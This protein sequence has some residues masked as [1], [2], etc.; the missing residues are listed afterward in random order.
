M[1]RTPRKRAKANP[2]EAKN[3]P[4]GSAELQTRR[5][6][7]DAATREVASQSERLRQELAA[8]QA[9]F[10]VTEVGTAI[11]FATL[12]LDTDDQ[13]KQARNTKNARTGYDTAL[14]F[15]HTAALT[16]DQQSEYRAK[17]EELKKLLR[18]LGEAV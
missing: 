1:K 15:S 17:L 9:D 18:R 12:A 8:T 10:V 6:R 5:A 2:T 16:R 3:Q 7:L 13:D 11:T 4:D 14:H